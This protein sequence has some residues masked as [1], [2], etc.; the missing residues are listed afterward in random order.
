MSALTV[1]TLVLSI[2]FQLIT[3]H[4]W[5]GPQESWFY[6]TRHT[7]GMQEK[8]GNIVGFLWK[9]CKNKMYEITIATREHLSYTTSFRPKH[10]IKSIKNYI[11][12][13]WFFFL[14]LYPHWSNRFVPSVISCSDI[15]NVGFDW[16][17]SSN[18][19]CEWTSE[20]CFWEQV[21]IRTQ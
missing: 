12:N 3:T 14:V 2:R 13:Q 21:R 6:K 15:D 19:G 18:P 10:C 16:L 9:I 7:L 1:S 5:W 17:L 8:H 4:C 11:V 20:G